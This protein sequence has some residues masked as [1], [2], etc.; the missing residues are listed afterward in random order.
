MPMIASVYNVAV[1]ATD[2]IFYRQ[3]ESD[4]KLTPLRTD[5][6]PYHRNLGLVSRGDTLFL[7]TIFPAYGAIYTSVDTGVHWEM[8]AV[9]H[10]RSSDTCT[11]YLKSM[12]AAMVVNDR[13]ILG[14][15][16]CDDTAFIF[17]RITNTQDYV[18][19]PLHWLDLGSVLV[20]TFDR[21]RGEQSLQLS[22]DDGRTWRPT[23]FN[24]ESSTARAAL[25]AIAPPVLF[26][27]RV[28]IGTNHVR[29]FDPV[30]GDTVEAGPL[31][32]LDPAEIAGIAHETLP[33][34]ALA[35]EWQPN[36]M[37]EDAVL[38]ID[39]EAIIAMTDAAGVPVRP[40]AMRIE[41]IAGKLLVTLRGASLSAG[42]YTARVAG[43]G[44][45]EYRRIVVVR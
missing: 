19:A 3:Q 39:P 10:Y 9:V 8:L 29:V 1:I 28:W 2:T 41:T 15:C 30:R 38:E 4:G 13:V 35:G 11:G 12:V 33:M 22:Y 27:G 36:P 6:P 45:V 34:P 16:R 40:E 26:Q 5:L 18:P 25:R 37:V 31:W 7:H 17:D 44:G 42:I 21:E 24:L 23:H 20:G 43:K 14:G 32:S